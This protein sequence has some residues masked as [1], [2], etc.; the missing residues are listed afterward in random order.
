MN[1]TITIQNDISLLP[2]NTF[3]VDCLAKEF[4]CVT[5]KEDILSLITD[6]RLSE[7]THFLI[8]WWW[9]NILFTQSTFDGLVIKNEILWKEVL[10]ETDDSVTIRV[11]AGENRDE[12]VQWAL[13]QGYCWLENLISIPWSVWA[14][15]MQNIWAYGKEVKEFIHSVEAIQLNNGK[16]ITLSNKECAFDYRDSIFKQ[17]LKGKVIITAVTFVLP[18][19]NQHYIP[20]LTYWAIK[21]SLWDQDPTPSN[22]AKIIAE[23]RAKKLPDRSRI[24]TAW[25][26]F[27]NPI[28]ETA[29][30]EK[31]LHDHPQLVSYDAWPWLT[32]LSAW[33]LIDQSWL[34]WITQWAVGTYKNHALVLVN[35]WGWTGEEI[36]ALATHIQEKVYETFGV[37]I[38][39]EVNFI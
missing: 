15:P 18:K 33:Q 34:K 20:T 5:K 11:W 21:D 38:R 7:H 35:H 39:P 12:F 37:T 25:S 14:A 30:A 10:A 27:K 13:E 9:S 8:L 23:I 29:T 19:Y 3:A 6:T 26:F 1:Q 31:I 17:D 32:K 24:G 22:I 36:A 2:Y 28:L 4:C 16:T